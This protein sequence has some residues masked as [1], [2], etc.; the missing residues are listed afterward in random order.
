MSDL[1][2]SSGRRVSR[3]ARERRAYRLLLVGGGAGAIALVTLVL[4]IVGAVGFGWFLLAT[5]VM[6]VCLLLFRR[7]VSS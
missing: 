5:V 2:P 3:S 6:V 4:A 7:A 1:T